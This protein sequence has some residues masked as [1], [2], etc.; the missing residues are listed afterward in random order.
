MQTLATLNTHCAEMMGI[1]DAKVPQANDFEKM[2]E[3]QLNFHYD[4]AS[5]RQKELQQAYDIIINGRGLDTEYVG[6]NAG[7]LKTAIK[8]VKDEY[9]NYKQKNIAAQKKLKNIK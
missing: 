8:Q 6:K 2:T 7:T 5:K 3:Q 9:S 4:K 1:L